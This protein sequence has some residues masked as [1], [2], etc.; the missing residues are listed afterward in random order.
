MSNTTSRREES[1]GRAAHRKEVAARTAKTPRANGED[2]EDSPKPPPLPQLHYRSLLRRFC[3]VSSLCKLSIPF[4]SHAKASY[5]PLQL[6]HSS[7]PLPRLI[8]CKSSLDDDQEEIP[9]ADTEVDLE[10]DESDGE[11]YEFDVDEFEQEAK[12]AVREY[13]SS[14]SRELII[15]DEAD[16][17]KESRKQRRRKLTVKEI[18]DHFL[19]KV[20]IVGRPNVGKSALFNRLVGENKAIVVDEPG[21]TR[22]RLYGRSFWGDHE[23]MVVD[24]GGVI[25]VSKPKNEV[26]D[27]LAIT[28]TI[29]MEGIPLASREAAVAR[30]PS[31]IEKLAT[32]AVEESSAI[33]FLVDGQAGLTVADVE[34]GTIINFHP[35]LC[36]SLCFS[37]GHGKRA[38]VA[39]SGS[40]TEALSVNRA[41]RTIRRSDVVA[42]VIEAMACITEQD[43][44][45]AER[46]EKEGKGFLIVVNKWDTIP[47]KNQKTAVYY[48]QD[49]LDSQSS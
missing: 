46:I 32:A 6:I 4:V 8:L 49:V 20:A 28:T 25:T 48:K 36:S 13:S 45:I 34:I 27:E 10:F 29:G 22:D 2:G 14:L 44:K 15:D 17:R 9:E 7:S 21:V 38:V 40:T 39:S 43:F 1:L 24:T 16:T 26:M 47:N 33:I 12:V 31:M 19:S 18:P 11:D 41:F 35:T 3:I 37:S 30:M 23:F 5:F 42:L